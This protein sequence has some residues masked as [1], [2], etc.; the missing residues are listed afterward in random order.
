MYSCTYSQHTGLSDKPYSNQYIAYSSIHYYATLHLQL[1]VLH[2]LQLLLY[3]SVSCVSRQFGAPEFGEGPASLLHS[4]R[5]R[6]PHYGTRIRRLAGS[7][8]QY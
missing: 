6:L 4:L 5:V 8:L 3:L 2:A 1:V 7:V